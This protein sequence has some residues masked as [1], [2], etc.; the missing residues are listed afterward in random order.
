VQVDRESGTAVLLKARWHVNDLEA[1]LLEYQPDYI[2]GSFFDA[3][4][5]GTALVS[6]AQVARLSQYPC[7]LY[8]LLL[9]LRHEILLHREVA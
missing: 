4:F 2:L 8:T 6:L 9:S 3:S 5:S 1:T 7:A